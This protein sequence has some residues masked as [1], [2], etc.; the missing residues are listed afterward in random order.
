MNEQDVKMECLRLAMGI[1][2]VHGATADEVVAFAEK[3]EKY[4]FSRK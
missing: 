4:V 2:A 1:L 3:L